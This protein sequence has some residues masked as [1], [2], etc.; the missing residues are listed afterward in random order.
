MRQALHNANSDLTRQYPHYVVR[1]VSAEGEVGRE[2]LD[3]FV[4][5]ERDTPV[6]ATT[7]KLLSTGVD[8]PTCKNIVL[9]K[10]IGS[11]VDFKQIIGRG[12][13]LFPDQ[14]KLSFTIIDYSGATAL[15]AD[16]DFDGT[17]ERIVE[18]VI[19][20]EGKTISEDIQYEDAIT[21]EDQSDVE[22][23]EDVEDRARKFY[24]D[25]GEVYVTAEAVYILVK[26][27]TSLNVVRYE[28]YV[29]DQIRRLYPAASD[30][31]ATWRSSLR[32]DQVVAALESR[33]V[34][35]AELAERTGLQDADPFD[36]LVHIAWNGALTSRRDRASRLRR[37]HHDFFARFGPDAREILDD[38]L[39]KY[40]D[41]GVDQLDDLRIL[42][43]PPLSDRGTPIEI[44]AR[45]GGADELRTAVNEMQERIYAA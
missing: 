39:N 5:P 6:I 12:T 13:R 40:A 30:L 43:V 2:H 3:N 35:L 1:I 25:D 23:V 17:P 45:F 22:H 7:S 16:P 42:E 14:D 15:F 29:A 24:I 38:L 37:E 31:R 20:D 8:I 33:G 32:R 21:D 27:G 34:T 36:L 41:H 19:D 26:G 4:D 9:F 10:P 28:D 11:I 44:A 18:T